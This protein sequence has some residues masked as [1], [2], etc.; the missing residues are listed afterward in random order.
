MSICG[1]NA[2]TFGSKVNLSLQICD[3]INNFYVY[4]EFICE[5]CYLFININTTCY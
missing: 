4:A 5:N 1:N 3:K 2:H